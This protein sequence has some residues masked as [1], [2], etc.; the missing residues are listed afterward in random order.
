MATTYD[1]ETLKGPELN[2]E[3]WAELPEEVPGEIVEGRLV[4]EEVPEP[5]HELAIAYLAYVLG[6]WSDQV[7]ALVF[8][9]GLHIAVGAKHGRKPDLSVYFQGTRPSR[10][11]LVTVPPDLAV[12]VLSPGPQNRRRDRIQK[13]AEYAAFGIRWYW[14]LDPEA[15]TLDIYELSE[16]GEYEPRLQATSGSALQVPGCPG[17]TLDLSKLWQK[18]DE[19][20]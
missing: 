13:F 7:G 5:P 2:L 6:V 10:N 20:A 3:E 15:R 8:T 18:L 11:A 16:K 17:L 1:L 4:E 12:E 19:L 14:L 9:S